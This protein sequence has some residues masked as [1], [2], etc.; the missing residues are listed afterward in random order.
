MTAGRSNLGVAAWVPTARGSVEHSWKAYYLLLTTTTYF[1]LTTYY[2]SAHRI[3]VLSMHSDVSALRSYLLEHDR[4][5]GLMEWAG[6]RPG[7]RGLGPGWG[8]VGWGWGGVGWG[9]GGVGGKTAWHGV[10]RWGGVS[11]LKC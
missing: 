2:Y 6:V 8:G 5:G 3:P 10:A 11:Y 9:G 4:L 1:L 7:W